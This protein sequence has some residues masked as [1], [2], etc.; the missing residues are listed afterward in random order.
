MHVDIAPNMRAHGVVIGVS[1]VLLLT[2]GCATSPFNWAWASR[3]MPLTEPGKTR[4]R[5]TLQIEGGDLRGS[6]HFVGIA[7]SGGGSRAAAFSG[8]VLAELEKAE[9]LKETHAISTVSGGSLA[10]AAYL[11]TPPGEW[12][13]ERVHK[14]FA[15]N[16]QFQ[17]FARW[18]LP[19]H[20]VRYWF[21]GFDRSDIMALIFDDLIFKQSTFTDLGLDKA[22]PRLLINATSFVRSE[23]EPDWQPFVFTEEEFG[24][25]GADLA[26]YPIAWAVMASGAFP[27]AFHNVTLRDYKQGNETDESRYHH[28]F[29]GGAVDNLGVTTLIRLVTNAFLKYLSLR[30]AMRPGP[31]LQCTLII[32]DAHTIPPANV[33]EDRTRWPDTRA[34][35]DFVLDRNYLES[36]SVLLSEHRQKILEKFN[37]RKTVYVSDPRVEHTGEIMGEC[38]VWHIALSSLY[39]E[40]FQR[41]DLAEAVNKIPTLYA[42]SSE[43]AMCLQEAAGTLVRT[44]QEGLCG[45]DGRLRRTKCLEDPPVR[46]CKKNPNEKLDQLD[47]YSSAP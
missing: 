11:L 4:T 12:T 16:F 30:P 39:D 45:P 7:L 29:D 31:F 38:L 40:R 26:S 33:Y 20:A 28:L 47:R 1:L 9:I 14:L 25:L 15:R 22:R 32:V 3:N 36:V 41:P 2:S 19:W 42:L 13:S 24:K 6:S 10:G 37:Q 17:W 21:T 18:F 23:R 46:L 27:G 34:F 8:F 44:T 43:E 35:F 5:A